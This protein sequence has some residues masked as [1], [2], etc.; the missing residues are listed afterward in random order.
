MKKITYLLILQL[1]FFSFSCNTE[2]EEKKTNDHMLIVAEEEEM[3]TIFTKTVLEMGH[4]MP[5]MKRFASKDEIEN[6]VEALLNKQGTT[7]DQLN[8]ATTLLNRMKKEDYEKTWL[9]YLEK[10]IVYQGTKNLKSTESFKRQVVLYQTIF[11]YAR[12]YDVSFPRLSEKNR[13]KILKLATEELA[14]TSGASSRTSVEDWCDP[15]PSCPNICMNR[16]DR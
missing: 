3:P 13:L 14:K 7:Q 2:K 4:D 16:P 10:D 8:I 11:K 9:L 5:E 1:L 15:Q 6:T 12:D